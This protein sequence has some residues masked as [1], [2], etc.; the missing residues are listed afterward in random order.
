MIAIQRICRS[1]WERRLRSYGCYP[2]E[3]LT[4]LNTAEWWRWPF[5]APPFTVPI[6]DEDYCNMRAYL[7]LLSD[8]SRLAPPEWKFLNFDG[9]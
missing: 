8:M 9:L 1:D 6:D 3:G 7:K 2:A 4:P 5:P